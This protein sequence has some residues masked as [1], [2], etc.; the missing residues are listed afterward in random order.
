MGDRIAI[1]SPDFVQPRKSDDINR[2][3]SILPRV[4]EADNRPPRENKYSNN[5][6]TQKRRAKPAFETWIVYILLETVLYSSSSPGPI[7]N[8]THLRPSLRRC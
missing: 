3:F 6:L 2:L 7:P 8:G 4:E 5:K 1:I